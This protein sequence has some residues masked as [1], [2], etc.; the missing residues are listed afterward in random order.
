MG[1][2]TVTGRNALANAYATAYPYLTLL[3]ALALQANTVVGA[4]TFAVDLSVQAGDKIVFDKGQVSE[5]E[6]T[7]VTVTGS[8]PYTVSSFTTATGGSSLT[9]AHIISG[10]NQ[11]LQSHIPKDSTTV[12]EVAS[13]TRVAANWASAANSAVVASPGTISVPGQTIGAVAVYSAST[14]GT[15][16]DAGAIPGQQYNVAGTYQPVVSYTQ[17]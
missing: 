8:G 16:A 3:R 7:V 11:G 4:T 14:S 5:E 12:H 13:I 1:I 15:Y 9:K 6:V 10:Q 2:A 17:T